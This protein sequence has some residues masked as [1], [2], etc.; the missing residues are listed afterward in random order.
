MIHD[1]QS[2]RV[3]LNN[4]V[5]WLL[6]SCG[7]GQEYQEWTSGPGYPLFFF[8]FL[9]LVLVLFFSLPSFCVH[10]HFEREET[11]WQLLKSHVI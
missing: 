11:E 9:V 10:L 8:Y 1:P 6:S 5:R 7:V 2:I 4:C 3:L